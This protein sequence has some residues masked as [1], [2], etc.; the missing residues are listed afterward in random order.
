[1]ALCGLM[2]VVAG[3]LDV[4]RAHAAEAYMAGVMQKEFFLANATVLPA[5]TG[6]VC[7]HV[8]SGSVTDPGSTPTCTVAAPASVTGRGQSK[9]KFVSGGGGLQPQEDSTSN[10]AESTAMGANTVSTGAAGWQSFHFLTGPN[11]L[12][13]AW[14]DGSA[15][16]T[17]TNATAGNPGRS[18]GNARD[19]LDFTV[20]A[21]GTLEYTALVA[22]FQ[23]KADH[24]RAQ[25]RLSIRV[26]INNVSRG[27]VPLDGVL[28]TLDLQTTGVVTSNSNVSVNLSVWPQLGISQAQIDAAEVFLRNQLQPL[29]RRIRRVPRRPAA[30]RPGRPAASHPPRSHHRHHPLHRRSHH[31]RPDPPGDRRRCAGPDDGGIRSPS[32]SRWSWARRCWRPGAGAADAPAGGTYAPVAHRGVAHPRSAAPLYQVS[33]DVS[34]S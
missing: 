7:V 22:D 13:G 20:S 14:L 34:L 10:L 23:I 32:R 3:G 27:G 11:V 18:V 17:T 28:W 21:P 8:K 1:M 12:F 30:V 15:Q 2:C 6:A 19:P 31:R 9:A 25:N 4:S 16:V 29:E 24:A 5:S 26:T 33:R